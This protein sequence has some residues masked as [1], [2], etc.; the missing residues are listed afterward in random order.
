MA[1][2]TLICSL[3]ALCSVSTALAGRAQ[4]APRP[5]SELALESE[6]IGTY[7]RLGALLTLNLRYRLRMYESE[8]AAFEDNFVGVSFFSQ[9]SPAFSQNGLVVELAPASFLRLRGGYQLVTYFGILGSMHA[10]DDCQAP[11]ST[12]DRDSRCDFDYPITPLGSG[13]SDR[14]NRAWASAQLRLKVG[15]VALIDTANVERWWFREG[16]D[17]GANDYWYNELHLLPQLREDTAVLNSVSLVYEVIPER[18]PSDLNLMVGLSERLAWAQ[19]T[20]YMMH[21][22]GVLALG[23]LP[24]W[25]GMTDAAVALI[26]EWYTHDRYKGGGALP[27]IGVLVSATTPNLL[28]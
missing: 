12:S 17:S 13:E 6:L 22:M 25:R 4:A 15:P 18:G 11:L 2:R 20:D 24:K 23:R 14:G 5:E 9:S 8:S 21:R 26:L 3:V 27:F 19:G 28:E 1:K 10:Y 16:W 7:N